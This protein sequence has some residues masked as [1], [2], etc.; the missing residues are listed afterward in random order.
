MAVTEVEWRRALRDFLGAEKTSA[1]SS[2]WGDAKPNPF[3]SQSVNL[4]SGR[5][6]AERADET[7]EAVTAVVAVG[8]ASVADSRMTTAMDV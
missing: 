2:G 4:R 6:C 3:D 1:L 7:A 5:R 8:V